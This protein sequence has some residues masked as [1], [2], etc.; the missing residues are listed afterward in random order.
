[1]N[2]GQRNPSIKLYIEELVLRGFP[3]QDRER[4]ARSIE[5]ELTRLLQR[6]GLPA[7]LQQGAAIPRINAGSFNMDHTTTPEKAGQQISRNLYGG[8]KR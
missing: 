4:V 8:M 1:M 7:G 6:E 5:K 3:A 2:H